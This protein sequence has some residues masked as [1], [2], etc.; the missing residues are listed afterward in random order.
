LTE[1]KEKVWTHITKGHCKG[2]SSCKQHPWPCWATWVW[3][4]R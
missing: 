3:D 4:K 1:L 2:C